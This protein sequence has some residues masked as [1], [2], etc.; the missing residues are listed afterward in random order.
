MPN[1]ALVPALSTRITDLDDVVSTFLDLN[2]KLRTH[3]GTE[4]VED[5]SSVNDHAVANSIGIVL[6]G[7]V[8][9]QTTEGSAAA[10]AA[11]ERMHRL[12]ENP[13]PLTVI[14]PWFVFDEVLIEEIDTRQRGAGMDFTAKLIR[15]N[16]VGVDSAGTNT[17]GPAD[18]R[19]PTVN[20][21][22]VISPEI[23]EANA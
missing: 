20:R 22:R 21:G 4:P 14:T 3:V 5:G 9:D 23:A 2:I 18:G 10:A 6:S 17:S 13:T 1:V 8:S 12:H 19:S 16:R 11:F 7:T 15:L